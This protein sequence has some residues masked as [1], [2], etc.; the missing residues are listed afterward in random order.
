MCDGHT[1]V[2]DGL[3]MGLADVNQ[4]SM[5]VYNRLLHTYVVGQIEVN[6]TLVRIASGHSR[7]NVQTRV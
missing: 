3:H 4:V 1:C 2:C 6:G 7:M 5:C